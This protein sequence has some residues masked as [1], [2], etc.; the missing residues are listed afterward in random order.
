MEYRLAFPPVYVTVDVVLLTVRDDRLQVLM[1]KRGSKPW[2]GWWA[3]PG[4]FIQQDEDLAD[5]AR[6]EL[7]EETGVGWSRRIWSNWRPSVRRIA[8]RAPVP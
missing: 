2:H 7:V 6:R 1:V 8:T 4:G 3:L 5:A